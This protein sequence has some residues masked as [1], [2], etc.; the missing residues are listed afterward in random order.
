MGV[1][2]RPSSAGEAVSM[3]LAGLGWL[4][5]ADLTEVPVSVRAE[6]LRELEH[7]RSVQTVAHA[8]VLSAFDA[9]QGCT[10]DGQGSSRAWLRWRTGVT[11]AEASASVG[12]VRR[13]AAHPDVAAD[14]RQAKV[15][16]SWA[17]YVCDLT[18]K[19]PESARGGAD[20]ILLDGLAGGLGLADLLGLVEE[21]RS[22]LG[23]PDEDKDKAFGDRKLR[24]A[25]TIGGA[26]RLE[27]DLTPQCAEAVRA[28]LDALGKKLGPEDERT[29]GQRR[30]DALQDACR[31]LIGSGCL[32]DRAGQPTQIQLH[33]SLEELLRRME[34]TGPEGCGH[35]GCAPDGCAPEGTASDGIGP[36]GTGPG[37]IGPGG[38]GPVPGW[39][40]ARPGD[41][42][43][44]AI[45]PIVTGNLDPE[46]L[47]KLVAA[48]SG[49]LRGA[50]LAPDGTPR[51]TL[52]TDSIRDLIVANAAALLSGPRGLASW[53]RRRELDGVAGS[54]SL[55]LDTGTSTE[56][57]P[58]HLRRA[59][60]LRDR[61]C[62]APGCDQPPS[63]CQV[64]H[65]RRRSKGGKTKLTNLMLL[66]PFHHLILVHEWGWTISLN[67]D[68]TTTM[69]NPDGTKVFHSHSPPAP[70]A[71]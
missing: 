69:R 57:V 26:G 66:C 63:A 30:H 43:D 32:P 48:V 45:V 41:E 42:C 29:A 54:V 37:G 44:A 15:S 31:R 21:I 49:P 68:G 64:H 13:L 28:V 51:V 23:T 35:D 59:V 25:T 8:A 16:A 67:G 7:V 70:A 39:P 9:G 56:T 52:N 58:A 19:L 65:V 61:H 24:L 55:P 62:A 12:W 4:A 50:D 40:L 10:E 11:G 34:G 5:D 18:D 1:S 33:L 53:L 22:Q 3:V 2:G 47:D 46:L 38:A 71:A 20:R 36:D 6:C 60:I 27:G 17:R 14:L